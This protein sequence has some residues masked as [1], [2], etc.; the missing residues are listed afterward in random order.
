MV[1]MSNDR[2]TKHVFLYDKTVC[3]DNWSYDIKLLFQ[4]PGIEESFRN[5]SEIDIESISD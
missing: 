2:L 1:N 4:E 5:M 3:R